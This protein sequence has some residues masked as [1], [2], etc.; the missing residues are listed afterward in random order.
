MATALAR[1]C[2]QSGL[3]PGE[4]VLAADPNEAARAAFL[5]QVPEARLAENNQQVLAEATL[6]V[7]A[8]KP[9]IM[10]TLLTDISASVTPAHL[11]VS[12]AAGVTL[13]KLAAGLPDNTRL[14]RVMPNTP[15]LIGFGAS[16]Y[17]QGA[18]ATED[19]CHVVQQVLESVGH[20][21]QVEEAMLDAVT[22]LSGSGPA[23]LYRVIESLAVGAVASGLPEDLA[24]ELAA[25]TTRGAAEMVLSTG[26]SPAE[27]CQQVTSPGGTTLA[28]LEAFDHAGGGKPL[29][30]AVEAATKRSLELGQA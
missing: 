11:F 19:D 4:R 2:V 14:I 7:L 16:G 21:Y 29:I 5:Q 25:H 18:H 20:A 27:L 8:V 24:L 13:K 23:F 9:Q 6:V 28:G 17:S 22:G 3:V 15:C 30:A 26:K 1:G 12:I 10:P